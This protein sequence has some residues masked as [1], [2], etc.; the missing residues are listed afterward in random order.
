[1]GRGSPR[2][3]PRLYSGNQFYQVNNFSLWS[4]TQHHHRQWDKL[5]IKG[6]QKLL[7]EF[8]NKIEIC[9]CGTSKDKRASQES[10]WLDMQWD[11]E[12][13]ASTPQ[14]SQARLGR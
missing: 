7:R 1:M 11:K 4:T 5:H 12:K 3:N 14:K 8:G 9:I 10:Q 6:V 2:N 13:T